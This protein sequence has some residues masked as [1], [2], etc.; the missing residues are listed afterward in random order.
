MP[1]T[2]KYSQVWFDAFS[3]TNALEIEL[4][5]LKGLLTPLHS[6]DLIH[7]VRIATGNLR[8]IREELITKQAELIRGM[9]DADKGVKGG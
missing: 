3:E 8:V 5:K 6:P 7:L 9:R 2:D 1:K 4:V